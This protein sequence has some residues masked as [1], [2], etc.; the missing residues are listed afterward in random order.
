MDQL[1][2]SVGVVGKALRLSLV[3]GP[4]ETGLTV[5]L[6][7]PAEGKPLWLH[8]TAVCPAPAKYELRLDLPTS[9]IQYRVDEP[10]ASCCR[11]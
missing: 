10:F 2:V 7:R 5:K 1:L 3:I 4:V 8:T 9:E 11:S 6:Y